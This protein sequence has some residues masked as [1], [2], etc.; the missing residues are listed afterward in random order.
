MV[1]IPTKFPHGATAN[2]VFSA[3]LPT[4][5]AATCVVSA[6][7]A[8]AASTTCDTSANLAAEPLDQRV[9]RI[10]ARA[11]EAKTDVSKRTLAGNA[12]NPFVATEFLAILIMIAI[13]FSAFTRENALNTRVA[14]E[15]PRKPVL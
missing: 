6:K 5:A 9:L 8:T 4:A 2:C 15:F 14:G 1:L 7:F 13:I 3:K 10:P 12:A 11:A